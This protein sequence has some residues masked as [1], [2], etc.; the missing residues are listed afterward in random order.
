MK[1][2]L[3]ASHGSVA[4][5]IKS[6]LQILLSDASCVT[7]ID[8]YLVESDA[9]V[10]I[11]DWIA[12]VNPDDEALMFS[13]LIGGSVCN[14]IMQFKPEQSGIVHVAGFNLITVIECLLSTEPLTP[15]NVDKIVA[16]GSQQMKRVFV[17][18][19][20]ESHEETDDSFFS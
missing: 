11:Q 10:L 3:I 20:G 9:S 13:D 17:E 1:K 7:A 19:T 2:L 15:D 4:S 12:S 6:A 18:D 5:G 16:A 8:C 14:T